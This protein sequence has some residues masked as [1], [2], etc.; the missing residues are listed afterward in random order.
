MSY[1][2]MS[3]AL[4]QT[5]PTVSYGLSGHH[6]IQEESI[7]CQLLRVARQLLRWL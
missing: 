2:I 6:T 7:E 4:K 5:P 1:A 3:Y